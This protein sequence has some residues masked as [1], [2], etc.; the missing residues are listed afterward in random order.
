MSS[1][2]L[3]NVPSGKTPA[4]VC[5]QAADYWD[6]IDQMAPL[7]VIEGGEFDGQTLADVLGTDPEVQNDLRAV[8]DWLDAGNSEGADRG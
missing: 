7:I 6:L 2:S 8:A 5:R 4:Q 3:A 1:E